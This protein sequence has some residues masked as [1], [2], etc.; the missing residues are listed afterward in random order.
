MQVKNESAQTTSMNRTKRIIMLGLMMAMSIVLTRFLSITTLTV[1]IGFAFI[2]L[3]VV[4]IAYGPIY[5]G[6]MGALADV[7]GVALFP[8]GP[9]FPGFTL[10][11][12]MTG[13]IYGVFLYK[14][15]MKFWR[16]LVATVIVSIV[17]RVY[18]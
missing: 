15:P 8:T 2:P 3:V 13:A 1:R 12:F 18:S 9:Y 5:A 7:I 10:T 6:I 14:K 11:A 16:V 4:A 17:V